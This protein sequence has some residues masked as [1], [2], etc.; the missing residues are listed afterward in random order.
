MSDIYWIIWDCISEFKSMV[1]CVGVKMIIEQE[2]SNQTIKGF[3]KLAEIKGLNLVRIGTWICLE[4][5]R[6]GT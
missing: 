1:M 2:W 6:G 3:K 4:R 5:E